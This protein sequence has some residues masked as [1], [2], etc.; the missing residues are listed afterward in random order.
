MTAPVQT[1]NFR[2]AVHGLD[3]AALLFLD[4]VNGETPD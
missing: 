2:S 3:T 1:A 4:D